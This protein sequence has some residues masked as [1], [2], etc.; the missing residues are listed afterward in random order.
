[1]VTR[2]IEKQ[3]NEKQTK[4][5]ISES[6]IQ[7]KNGFFS[8]YTPWWKCI[9]KKTHWHQYWEHAKITVNVLPILIPEKPYRIYT[10]VSRAMIF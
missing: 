10:L 9:I 1:M 8:Q 7:N 5:M 2:C 4:K 6:Q 3:D